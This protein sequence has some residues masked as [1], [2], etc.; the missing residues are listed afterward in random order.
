MDL[1]DVVDLVGGSLHISASQAGQRQV[2]TGEGHLPEAALLGGRALEKLD[3]LVGRGFGVAEVL[4][5][6]EPQVGTARVEELLLP[7]KGH[8]AAGEIIRVPEPLAHGV[9][10]Q[11]G[12]QYRAGLVELA[13]RA[14]P[15]AGE[16]D[17]GRPFLRNQPAAGH[18]QA[19]RVR[20]TA[21]P[22]GHQG[23]QATDPD[24]QTVV[25]GEF[26]AHVGG[27]RLG[28]RSRVPA[29][30]EA[31]VGQDPAENTRRHVQVAG[32]AGGG[33]RPSSFSNTRSRRDRTSSNRGPTGRLG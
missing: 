14:G 7:R 9:G 33:C 21:V 29:Q 18:R 27:A 5:A 10:L 11:Q 28:L 22:V 30:I 4:I 19:D 1:E 16:T 32:L 31:G 13:E 15:D 2:E 3:G 25:T 17:V 12:G 20:G 26:A 8:H 23:L 6:P 24:A